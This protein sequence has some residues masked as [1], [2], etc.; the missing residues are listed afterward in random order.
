[1]APGPAL[2]KGELVQIS[3]SG[4]DL[5]RE[6]RIPV[7]DTNLGSDYTD[8]PTRPPAGPSYV[9]TFYVG[10]GSE[11]VATPRLSYFPGTRLLHALARGAGGTW[12]LADPALADI[13]DR[14][15]ADARRGRFRSEPPVD[16]V[17][18]S[19][20]LV[21]SWAIPLVAVVAGLA[22]RMRIRNPRPPARAAPA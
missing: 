16:A 6:I 15:I 14:A 7:R 2:A 18:T 8:A 4:G 12:F 17:V 1:M 20:T 21:A 5:A 19:W 11:I 22:L 3:V 13:L 9:V 10:L